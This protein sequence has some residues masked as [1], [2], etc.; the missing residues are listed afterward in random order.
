MQVYGIIIVIGTMIVNKIRRGISRCW[1]FE[2]KF[3]ILEK[4]QFFYILVTIQIP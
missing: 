3:H 4:L 2:F 1:V